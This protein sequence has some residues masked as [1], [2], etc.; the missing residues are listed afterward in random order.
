[1]QT[2]KIPATR[3]YTRNS[4]GLRLVEVPG[5]EPGSKKE[6]TI[7]TTCVFLCLFSFHLGLR[8][9]PVAKP[10]R[11]LGIKDLEQWSLTPARK[12][13]ASGYHVL[14][15]TRSLSLLFRQRERNHCHFWLPQR[16]KERCNQPLH[17]PFAILSLSK[18][19]HPLEDWTSLITITENPLKTRDLKKRAP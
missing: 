5:I 16:F 18:P 3:K 2:K 7:S 1:M 11:L 12:L 9:P 4:N 17:A 15:T 10:A 14:P 6:F 13:T 19:V 8:T